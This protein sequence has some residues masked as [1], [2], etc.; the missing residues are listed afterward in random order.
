MPSS[1]ANVALNVPA[2]DGVP[3]ITPLDEFNVTPAGSAPLARLQEYGPPSPPLAANVTEYGALTAP[4]GRVDP[5]GLV[6]EITGKM[7]RERVLVAAGATPLESL[8]AKVRLTAEAA[9]VGVPLR[10]PA[11][12][13]LMPVGSVPVERLH[14]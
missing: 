7:V 2:T 6:M 12:E 10:T 4:L 8:T 11:A 9:I 5:G 3:E 14:V 1:A 13:K